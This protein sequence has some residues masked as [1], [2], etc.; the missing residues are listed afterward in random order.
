MKPV[1]TVLVIL[2]FVFNVTAQN[3]TPPKLSAAT[4]QFLWQLKKQNP[5]AL[6]PLKGV[7]YKQDAQKNIYVSTIIKVR[8]SFNEGSLTAI[9]ARVNTK[10]GSIWTVRVPLNSMNDFSRL[11]GI[12][13][14]EM[15]QPVAR[16]LDS[17]R[18]V[19]HVDSVQKG[20][21]LPQGY[22]GKNVIVG[23]VDEGFDYTHPTYYDTLY[24]NYRIKRVWQEKDTTG[25]PPSNFSYGSEYT[26]SAAILTL[27]QDGGG[28][29][30]TH[31]TGIAA[32][33]G[34]GSSKSNNRFRGMAYGSDIAMVAI[35]PTSSYWLTTSMSD[36]ID[37]INYL[38]QY[39]TS[40]SKPI[41]V[42][43][44][45]GCPLGP[46]DG[47]SLFSQSLD[48][49]VGAG[50]IFCI[51][52]GNNGTNVLHLQNTF[53]STDTVI[54]TFATFPPITDS[55]IVTGN[56]IDIWG[57]SG[58]SFCIKFSLYNTRKKNDSTVYFCLDDTTHLINLVGANQDTFSI[59]LTTVASENFNNEPH[60]LLQ[61]STNFS[62]TTN[63]LDS[64][65]LSI[66]G[67]S[68]KINMWQGYVLNNDGYY[69]S[70]LSN[71]YKWA[72]GGDNVST[73]S[74]L[75]STRSA[76]TVGAYDSKVSFI[77][78]SSQSLY[79]P[80]FALGTIAK[81]SS[82]GPTADGRTKPNITGPGMAVAS[83][84][85]SFDSSYLKGGSNFDITID[86]F[87][88][89]LNNRTYSYVLEQGTS[90]SGPAVSGI[91]ALL[92]EANPNLT[93]QQV[94]TILEETA[95]KD[96]YTGTIPTNGSNTWGYGKVNAYQA[97]K[98]VLEMEGIYH[99]QSSNLNCLVYPNPNNGNYAVE[100]IS[101]HVDDLT[102]SVFDLSGKQVVNEHWLINTGNNTYQ[103]NLSTFPAGIYITQLKSAGGS[104]TIKIVKE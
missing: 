47:T 3:T 73:I 31:V 13:Y 85:N 37:G 69:G 62:N 67:T 43:M 68:G 89:P 39:A 59:I 81:F 22:S 45:W 65:C 82:L 15:D 64:L 86:T 2:A 92:L 70:F 98:K 48:S 18:R 10:A 61:L 36:M 87:L 100:Y 9:G 27:M 90:M 5:V 32:G 66:K 80:G 50:K 76:I 77:N 29:H 25:T 16:T 12:Q 74:D 6:T 58:Q 78:V 71:G 17:A 91:V 1:I 79:Y 84:I 55:T 94:T 97:I 20:Y 63:I 99:L 33:S 101:D 21:G 41:V 88:S 26:D 57:D 51:S 72:V 23:V 8:P 54:N 75:A 40:V 44:S 102:L 38:F 7:V 93:P 11:N 30:G 28:I 60:M 34:Y 24:K 42:N 4:K 83:S 95:I 35:N 49:L 19:T 53:S 14:I 103:L 104:A 96:R 56:L 46:R 52:G